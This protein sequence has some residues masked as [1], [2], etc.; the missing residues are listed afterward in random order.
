MEET[1]VR[2]GRGIVGVP[3]PGSTSLLTYRKLAG[4]SKFALITQHCDFSYRA[5]I[6]KKQ[7]VLTTQ[8]KCGCTRFF[9]QTKK[10][11]WTI[12]ESHALRKKGDC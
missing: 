9:S 5:S 11:I 6:Q 8:L 2:Q 10:P 1:D 4:A 12:M 7:L 3:S